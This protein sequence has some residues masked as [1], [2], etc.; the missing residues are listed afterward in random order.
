MESVLNEIN[1]A[2]NTRFEEIQKNQ[3]SIL[4]ALS[5]KS[6]NDLSVLQLKQL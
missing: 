1:V 4:Y 5:P 6:D 2:I 3:L